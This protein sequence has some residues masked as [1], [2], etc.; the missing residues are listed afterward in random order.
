MQDRVLKKG[1]KVTFLKKGKFISHIYQIIKIIKRGNYS[2][3]HSVLLRSNMRTRFAKLFVS[4]KHIESLVNPTYTSERFNDK[5]VNYWGLKFYKFIDKI[6]GRFLVNHFHSISKSVKEHYITELGVSPSKITVV[7]RGREIIANEESLFIKS[8]RQKEKITFISVGRHEFQKG[9]IFLLMAIKILAEKNKNI[10]LLVLGRE[11]EET[12]QL[13]DFVK[14]NDLED[15]VK[16]IGYIPNI[17]AYLTEAD[18]FVFPSLYEGMGGALLEAMAAGLPLA[19]N[20]IPVFR[21]I[22]NVNENAVFFNTNN[23]DSIVN[24]LDFYLNDKN[25]RIEYG[26][27]SLKTFKENFHISLVNEELYKLLFSQID[28]KAIT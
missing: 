14:T 2:L 25:K 6:T 20:D 18:V 12:K 13:Y 17:N 27:K 28:E 8:Q 16:F 26:D 24:C 7:Y 19:L 10:E 1:Y 11:G 4:F 3:V 21:E 15:F 22:T 9:H 5:R 23:I